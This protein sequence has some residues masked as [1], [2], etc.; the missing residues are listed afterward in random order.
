MTLVSS[1]ITDAYRE[2]NLIALAA[3]P[4]TNQTNEALRR[5]NNI[6]LSSI[7][8]EVGD[9][10][11]DLTIGGDYD[12][13]TYVADWLPANCRLILNLDSAKTYYL[14]PSPYEGQ[15]FGIVDVLSNL[16]TYPVT[17][18]G[19]G[20]L[21]ESATTLTLNTDDLTREWLYRSDVG[22][23]VRVTTLAS[24]DQLPFPAEFDDYF[25]T[26]LAL[27]LN[28]RYGQA[29]SQETQAAL[30]RSKNQIRARYR[31]EKQT[32][33]EFMGRLA[34]SKY[35]TFTEDTNVWNG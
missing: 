15:R 34:T 27:R 8:Y 5:L 11:T 17:I 31:N 28:P 13:S 25:I 7:G 22:G 16:A 9:E 6:V 35:F 30:R 4:N 19:N 29:L 21:I 14:D 18:D 20:R 23:W 2:S 24:G 26:M 32:P 3:T 1:I 33:P 12:Q 10:L